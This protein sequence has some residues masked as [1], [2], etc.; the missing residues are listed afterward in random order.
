MTAK[1]KAKDKL[2]KFLGNPDN[3]FLTRSELSTQVLGY[4]K[5][6]HIYK[7]FTPDELDDIE[8]KTLEIRRSKYSGKLANVDKALLD[9]ANKGDVNAAKLCYQR[10]EN[11]SERLINELQG[12]V[13]LTH[14][15]ALDELE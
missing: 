15:Q 2:L 11:W 8:Q 13:S 10:F 14:E 3:V 9:K 1:E 6:N 5:E 12:G 7:L 4:K